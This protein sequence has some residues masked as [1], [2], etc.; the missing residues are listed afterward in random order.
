MKAKKY[1]N[2]G[3]PPIDP[4][5]PLKLDDSA[6]NAVK[7]RPVT[8]TAFREKLKKQLPSGQQ[9]AEQKREEQK[10]NPSYPELL[11]FGAASAI[12]GAKTAATKHQAAGFNMKKAAFSFGSDLAL[13]AAADYDREKRKKK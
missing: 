6:K 5:K 12:K 1:Q 7:A 10:L 4:K 8:T 3:R 11:V 2:G 13:D 9:W